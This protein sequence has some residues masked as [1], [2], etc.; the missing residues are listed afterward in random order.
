MFLQFIATI[1]TSSEFIQLCSD[2]IYRSFRNIFFLI[3]LS[4]GFDLD[5]LFVGIAVRAFDG[6]RVGRNLEGLFVGV[7]MGTFESLKVGLAET[8]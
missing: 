7:A 2:F 1:L 3:S 8:R 6:F 4:V 5:G